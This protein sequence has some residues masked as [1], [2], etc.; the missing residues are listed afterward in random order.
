MAGYPDGERGWG[1]A[2]API[3]GPAVR[4]RCLGLSLEAGDPQAPGEF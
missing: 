2:P 3:P 1:E 4:G